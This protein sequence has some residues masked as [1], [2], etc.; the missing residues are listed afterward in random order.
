MSWTEHGVKRGSL[1][2][3]NRVDEDEGMEDNSLYSGRETGRPVHLSHIS[4]CRLLVTN[5]STSCL[6]LLVSSNRDHGLVLKL[7]SDS[8]NIRGWGRGEISIVD[9]YKRDDSV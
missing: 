9:K 3:G 4:T 5:R 2:R 7:D 6:S 8:M 1:Q